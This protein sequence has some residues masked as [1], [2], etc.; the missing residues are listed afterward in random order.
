[1][2]RRWETAASRLS[3]R[4]ALGVD[5]DRVERLA[6]RHEQAVALGAAEA[7]GAADLRESGAADQ[8][9]R[10]RSH[11]Y[12]PGAHVAAGV[13]RGPHVA[14]DIAAGPVRTTL[15]PVDHEVAE[16]LHVGELVVGAHVEDVHLALAA[17][18]GITGTLARADDVQL[19]VVGR[20]DE[21]V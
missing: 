15:H 20:E 14:V 5:V 8:L 12:P 1:H 18:A 3:R 19:L 10:W 13:A 16:E 7:D 21:P 6:G 9:P 4:R 2:E 17:G 11:R